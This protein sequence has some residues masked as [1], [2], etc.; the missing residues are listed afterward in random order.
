MY[1][2]DLVEVY[3][4]LHKTPK[5]LEKTEI[6]VAFLKSLSKQDLQE[7]LH[8]LRGKVFSQQD[9]KYLHLQPKHHSFS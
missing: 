6:L 1:Y 7:V 5:R 9:S 4:A 8:L 2:K 3:E